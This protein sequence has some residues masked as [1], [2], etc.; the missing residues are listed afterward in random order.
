MRIGFAVRRRDKRTAPIL[1]SGNQATTNA[2]VEIFKY[3]DD[4]WYIE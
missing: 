3:C 1:L 2:L 4:D